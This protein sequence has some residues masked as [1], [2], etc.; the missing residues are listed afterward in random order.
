[1]RVFTE[2]A[3]FGKFYNY[4]ELHFE[5]WPVYP[6]RKYNTAALK[7]FHWVQRY[8]VLDMIMT[9]SHVSLLCSSAY[10]Q[11]PVSLKIPVFNTVILSCH[12]PDQLFVMST[13]ITCIPYYDTYNIS[14]LCACVS[15]D[16]REWCVGLRLPQ[17]FQQLRSHDSSLHFLSPRLAQFPLQL[18]TSQTRKK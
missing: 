17:F 15:V 13:S 11:V 9:H 4:S 16:W 5:P 18:A 10:I 6:A 1:M 7:K 8:E 14:I 12:V 3:S 2:C